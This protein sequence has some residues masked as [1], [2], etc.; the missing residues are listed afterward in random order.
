MMEKANRF[1]VDPI[2]QA[3]TG[4]EDEEEEEEDELETLRRRRLEQLKNLSRGRI[5]EIPG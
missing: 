5:M 1:S 4:E 3:K 2:A